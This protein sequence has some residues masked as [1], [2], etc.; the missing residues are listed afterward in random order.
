MEFEYDQLKSELNKSK[1]GIDFEEAQELWRGG[2]AK[3]SLLDSSTETRYM[4][5]GIFAGK[6]WSAIYT[7]RGERVRI[8]SVRR[9]REGEIKD[10]EED[11]S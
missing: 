7:Y 3:E 6:H 5:V 11:N 8:I 10:Y 1:H 4:L 9:S 2:N